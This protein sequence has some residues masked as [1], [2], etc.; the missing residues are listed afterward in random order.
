M[1]TRKRKLVVD[2][3]SA[4]DRFSA[5]TSEPVDESDAKNPCWILNENECVVATCSEA[6]SAASDASDLL[7][8]VVSKQALC[9]CYHESTTLPSALIELIVRYLPTTL[10]GVEC[11]VVY[12]SLARSVPATLETATPIWDTVLDSYHLQHP[13]AKEFFFGCLGS[14]LDHDG[15]FAFFQFFFPVFVCPSSSSDSVSSSGTNRFLPVKMFQSFFHDTLVFHVDGIPTTSCR[16]LSGQ[17]IFALSKYPQHLQNANGEK[18][19]WWYATDLSLLR[20][21]V[22]QT[23]LGREL[24]TILEPNKNAAV[25]RWNA[26]GVG[27]LTDIPQRCGIMGRYCFGFQFQQPPSSIKTRDAH[28]R[29]K[30]QLA[31]EFCAVV[32]RSLM[33]W[34]TWKTEI[35]NAPRHFYMGCSEHWFRNKFHNV[36]SVIIPPLRT[37]PNLSK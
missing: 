4:L 23:M 36:P 15:A 35:A 2:R 19:R 7:T 9:A 31:S 28:D 17:E 20:P 34:Q 10:T 25:E 30:P 27:I 16:D 13:L 6:P 3:A 32:R 21:C 33:I 1:L 11:Q 18:Q 22:F 12:T 14:L 8:I 24:L 5:R 29:A 26:P 37:N